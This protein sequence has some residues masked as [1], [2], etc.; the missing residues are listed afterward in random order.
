MGY[1][2]TEQNKNVKKAAMEAAK[3]K[4]NVPLKDGGLVGVRAKMNNMGLD[5][6]KIG[7]D[8]GYVT[9]NNLR[10]KPAEVDN[11]VSY[12]S[13]RDIQ[14]FVNEAYKKE[15]K[16]PVRVTDYP[17]PA[18]VGG[19]SYS[20]NGMVSVG[21]E[22]VPV[23]YMD[24]DRAVVDKAELE[25][26]YGNLLSKTGIRTASEINKNW[27]N[28]Y[29]DRL[30]NAYYDM[31]SYGDWSYNPEQDP[32]YQAYSEMYRREGERAY[33]DAAAKMMSRN[34]GNMTS[35]AQSVA[36]Q[37]LAYYMDKLSD[38]IPALQENAYERFKNGYE[39]RRQNYEALEKAAEK[40]LEREMAANELLKS[41]YKNWLQ[42]ERKRTEDAVGDRESAVELEKKMFE[43]AWANAEARGYFN[44][45]EAVLLQIP[46]NEKGEYLTPTDIKIQNDLKYFNEASVPQL[47]YKSWLAMKELSQKQQI[48]NQKAARD[49]QYDKMLAEYKAWLK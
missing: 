15:N 34:G 48:D 30:Q 33:R 9:Y 12:A 46:K 5:N 31:A 3:A 35:A 28:K 2:T 10:F 22:N 8:N 11:G 20:D 25:R 49:Y 1:I 47:D 14:S 26:A 43:N 39:M 38:K 36:N 45:S 24:G 23:L 16:N 42:S 13:N 6:S 37:Q 17:A 27:E 21:G 41:D 19:V 40:E 7:W 32:A 4:M 29:K 44:D 18:G